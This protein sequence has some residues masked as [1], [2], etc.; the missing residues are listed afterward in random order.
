[1]HVWEL[2]LKFTMLTLNLE[3][4]TLLLFVHQ[5]EDCSKRQKKSL[6]ALRP[7]INSSW[8]TPKLVL[9]LPCNWILSLLYL[10]S[11]K[12]SANMSKIAPDWKTYMPKALE[13]L[14]SSILEVHIWM[15]PLTYQRRLYL[16]TTSSF[17]QCIKYNSE[18]VLQYIK[19]IVLLNFWVNYWVIRKMFSCF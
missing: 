8:N 4:R 18:K 10:H 16:T 3:Q 15:S 12:H 9:N 7:T 19:W 13:T 11:C 17:E 6:A 1:M 14:V 2:D 5:S